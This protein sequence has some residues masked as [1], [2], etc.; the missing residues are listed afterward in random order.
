MQFLIDLVK[1]FKQ[2][3]QQLTQMLEAY[4]RRNNTPEP[5]PEPPLSPPPPHTKFAPG[6]Q[7]WYR[8]LPRRQ[9]GGG[10]SQNEIARGAPKRRPPR[11][12]GQ[13]QRRWSGV[14]WYY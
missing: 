8:L 13:Q 9:P 12:P 5:A 6:S 14:H 10:L 2:Q 4:E 11:R 7:E 3:Q 1:L